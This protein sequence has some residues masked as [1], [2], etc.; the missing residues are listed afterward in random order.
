MTE[1]NYFR[2][3]VQD[4]NTRA[5]RAVVSQMGVHSDVLRQHLQAIF[6]QEAGWKGSFLADPVFEAT[7]PW[8]D[9]PKTMAELPGELLHPDLLAAMDAPPDAMSEFRFPCT[10]PPY[11][12]QLA[13][14]QTLKQEPS[15]SL[16]VTSGPGSGKTECFLVPIL[17]DLVRERAATGP[18]TGVRALFLYPLNALINSQRDRLRAWS[19][20]FGRDIRFC[21]YNGDTPQTVREQAQREHPQEV[22]SRRLLRADPPPIL[23]TNATMLEYMLVRNDDEP[24]RRMSQRLL[25]WIVV[26]EAHSYVGSQAAELALLLRRVVHSFGVDPKQV[27]FVATSATIGGGD[28][29]ARERLR[30][31]LA[32][33]AGVSPDQ[34]SVVEGE[35]AVP[36]LPPAAGAREP[37]V[38]EL[39]SLGPE[40]R[41]RAL[42]GSE[43]A[44]GLRSALAR[45]GALTLS[46]LS[47]GRSGETGRSPSRVDRRRTLELLDVCASAVGSG[48]AF[49]PLRMHLFH[50][51]QVGIW[52]CGNSG[53]M[54][55]SGTPLDDPRWSFG[56]I[57]LE[58]RERC[59]ICGS[60]AFEV[61]ICSDCGQEYLALEEQ[62]RPDG[63]YLTP[64]MTERDEDEFQQ[65]LDRLYDPD[66]DEA[67]D[68]EAAG[69]HRA[70]ARLATAPNPEIEVRIQPDTGAI[71][72]DGGT[73]LGILLPGGPDGR[74]ACTRCS[75]RERYLGENFWP[76]RVGAPFFLSVAIPCLL[77]HTPPMPGSAGS[78][79]FGGRR[80]ITFSDS[81]QG[82]ARFA[83]KAQIDAERSHIR[84][85]LYHQVATRRPAS[86]GGGQQA[87]RDEVAALE[88]M[89]SRPPV[90]DRRLREIREQ[91]ESQEA[92][93]GGRLPWRDAIAA[94]GG[95]RAV[96]EWLPGQWE[97]LSLGQIPRAQVAEF[98]LL[99][100]F[101]RRPK[102]QTSLETLGLCALSYPGITA[103]R[104]RDLPAV[105]RQRGL[106]LTDWKDLLKVALDFFVRS[107]SAVVVPEHFVHWLGVPVRQSF[108]LGPDAD[109][110]ARDQRAWPQVRLG[111]RHSR[112]VRLLSLGLSLDPD[113]ADDRA[114]IN[115]ILGEAWTRVLP[116]LR[117]LPDGF[118]LDLAAA[119]ELREIERAWVCPITR[120]ILDS[121]FMGLTPYLPYGAG[122]AAFP[123]EPVEM[124]RLP[125]PFWARP[126]GEPIPESEVMDWLETDARVLDARGRG[127]WPE[128]SDRIAAGSEYFR[129]AE[130]SAQQAGKDLQRFERDFKD[131]RI[132]VL[133]CS[134]TMELGV[135]IGGLSAVAMNNAPP[136]PA[137]F[138]QRAGRAGRRGETTSTSLTMCK[139]TPHGEAVYANPK[140]PFSTPL[141]VPRVSLQ[142]ERIVQRH[143]NA[144]LLGQ[145]LSDLPG[146]PPTLSAGWF[147]EPS[148]DDG[149]SPCVRYR[150]WCNEPTLLDDAKLVRGISTVLR[151][152]ALDT[153]DPVAIRALV[154]SS[155][156]TTRLVQERWLEE[157][158]E[159]ETQL[160]RYGGTAKDGAATPAQLA[161]GRQLA[162]IRGE[163]LL[164]E[165]GAS[166][167]LPGYGFPTNV[168]PFVPTTLA[169]LRRDAQQRQAAREGGDDREDAGAR[170][171]GYPS[172]DLAVA[173]RDYAPGAEVV[174]NGRVYRSQGVALNWHVPPGDQQVRELQSFRHAWRCTGLGCGASGTR[175]VRVE[176]CPICGADGASIQQYEYLRPSGFAVDVLY[177]PHND[178]SR[179][180]YIPV[181]DPWITAGS[182]PWLSLPDPRTGR[183]RYSARGH[184][185]HWS[186]GLH[187]AGFAICLR[188]GRADSE[189]EVGPAAELP[190]N[191]DNHF[192]LRGGRAP[193]GR[194]RCEGCE[195][196]FAIKRHIWLGVESWTDVFELQLHRLADGEPVAE[197]AA[198][199]SIA[200][201]LR[202][203]L[204]ER[205]GVHER[206]IGCSAVASRLPT[207]A[208]TR[209]IVLYDVT[210]GGAGYVASASPELP[211]LLRRARE[212][213]DCPRRCDRAC[214]ACLLTFDTQHQWDELDRIAALR[215]LDARFVETLQIPT[216]LQVFGANTRMEYEALPVA[217]RREMQRGDAHRVDLFL[218]GDPAEWDAE[219][220]LVR[221]DLLRWSS[222]GRDLRIYADA[223]SLQS[224]EPAAANSLASLAEAAR[225]D[226]LA[227]RE[228]D[229][230][231]DPAGLIAE[232][233]GPSGVARWATTGVSA[234]IPGGSWG[235]GIDGSRTV[236]V[237][238]DERS[239]ALTGT[240]VTP[241]SLRR[242]FDGTLAELAVTTEFDG[243]IETFGQR[244]W[245]AL[246][247][248]VPGL[249]SRLA[250][251]SLLARILYADRYL[252]S[253]LT[254]RL[255]RELLVGLRAQSELWGDD[256]RFEVATAFLTR[257]GQRAPWGLGHNWEF[258][259]DRKRVTD[260]VLAIKGVAPML[261]VANARELAHVRELRL[262]W[263]DG[264]TW[265]LRLDQG[266]GFWRTERDERFPF[267][268]STDEQSRT[269]LTVKPRIRG[270]ST[271]HPSILYL[272]GV[273]G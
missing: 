143:L 223:K 126:S 255:L 178:V 68:A 179:P 101:F 76:A 28:P 24:I 197:P 127:V 194:T 39:A 173:I 214:Q 148:T 14:W 193:D 238:T 209:S 49:L 236:R 235:T 200:V 69:H 102:R 206:E 44:R 174:L 225:I 23:V 119:S 270:W 169:Q 254:V 218:A 202:Q 118:Q 134:T 244:F 91:L 230:A 195:E 67:G 50:R 121:T 111:R 10:R 106:S 170:R 207:G 156:E 64:R 46:E 161:I 185:F 38:G 263:K 239:D 168:V 269:L 182:E 93:R 272:G 160:G 90:L 237:R 150:E 166:G 233:R 21:L 268:R 250:N 211:E 52:S 94:L 40:E 187:G 13:A 29:Q 71:L 217:I 165:L 228:M 25:R 162:R 80:V 271:D 190:S 129:V 146:D 141:H 135:D 4:I 196:E 81:R 232:V 183:Y 253:P 163:Y 59:D 264:A 180:T 151:R 137:N 273:T 37:S 252:K 221:E 34:V 256:T 105:W 219:E 63:R 86:D 212:V 92:D 20:P 176:A 247:A 157:V 188:C 3:L 260:R 100:E 191:L 130:H 145:F 226:L 5:A 88:Q 257:S 35:R 205:L 84:S 74:L 243:G 125:A 115:E 36:D 138:L 249:D 57:F 222:E 97:D 215:V 203:A 108:V 15:Q 62:L 132:N 110:V 204:G 216:D 177:E 208:A 89:G 17:D 231:L 261:N 60:L 33:I 61:V 227:V 245:S 65:E 96:R 72:A 75:R 43:R 70:F 54:G 79:P 210:V 113:D 22:L 140:W 229:A 142:S 85:V 149:V 55:R 199:Y 51:T 16:V 246:R 153:Q 6:E 18:L 47:G 124:P 26:D 154:S 31:F 144:L 240:V 30:R 66:D 7:F 251:G 242:K 192:R 87:L 107:Y 58:Q 9:A 116:M 147:F 172:R 53:C 220:W 258:E 99:R 184:V 136:S 155:A 120:R 11:R 175:A 98:L 41:Y 131:G 213:L 265:Y 78:R 201:A 77:G 171:R 109:A 159:L 45:D 248:R 82:T 152:S 133:S 234:R 164:G 186:T 224:L 181:R 73:A 198:V 122:R 167:F 8:K 12:H 117:R 158:R 259:E 266:L 56:Q 27:R 139:A 19:A 112:L 128:F 83:V 2:S 241:G 48:Q 189:T 104:E 32:D 103:Q 267:D 123:C 1:S 95:D 42:L 262:E 114:T